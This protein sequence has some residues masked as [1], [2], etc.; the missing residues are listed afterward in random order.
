MVRRQVGWKRISHTYP[1]PAIAIYE[2]A[3]SLGRVQRSWLQDTEV[4]GQMRDL[5]LISVVSCAHMACS[6]S[7]DE[8]IVL[9]RSE[10]L[11]VR[12]AS[13]MEQRPSLPQ[14]AAVS[15]A[16][17]LLLCSLCACTHLVCKSDLRGPTMASYTRELL[18]FVCQVPELAPCAA[19]YVPVSFQFAGG[20]GVERSARPLHALFMCVMFPISF[21][22]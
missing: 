3:T 7:R 4:T 16:C 8:F 15:A 10:H 1:H 2:L 14:H 18:S 20:A 12:S 9:L 21:A 22:R 13:Q 6:H 17:L 19:V 11:R 5:G